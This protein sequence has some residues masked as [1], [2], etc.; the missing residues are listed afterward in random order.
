MPTP[1]PTLDPLWRSTTTTPAAAIDDRELIRQHAG[2]HATWESLQIITLRM[3]EIAESYPPTVT[4]IQDW[5]DE[6]TSLEQD[7]ADAVA[8]GTAHL[9]NAEEYQG[10]VPGTTPTRD[11][12]LKQAGPLQWDTSLLSVRYKFGGAAGPAGTADGQRQQRIGMLR[13]R[14]LESLGLEHEM[15]RNGG[16][17]YVAMVRS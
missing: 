5:L 9:A 14:I 2:W 8:D 7:H 17:G 11:Q 16:Y 3:N 13:A 6:I 15:T 4:A 12:Q 1:L 10:P